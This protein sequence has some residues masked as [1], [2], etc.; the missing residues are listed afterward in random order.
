M[1][2][3]LISDLFEIRT[4]YTFRDAISDLEPGK[5]ALV[6]AGDINTNR[7]HSVSRINFSGE[8]H[9]L[10]VNDILLSARG[11]TAARTVT[12]DFLPAVAGSS[13]IVLRPKSDHINTRF[14]A[15]Y[16]NSRY[17]QSAFRKI[18]SGGYIKTLRKT[19]LEEILVPLPAR[20]TQ[21][22]LVEL[23]VNISRQKEILRTKERL[24]GEVYENAISSVRGENS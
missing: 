4:G 7:L 3:E 2:M 9:L 13:V 19:E 8:K 16:L 17:G 5:V 15:T 14:V 22:A 24:L 21:D 1:I 18:M 11:G 23:G 12:Q 10:K 20:S 6:Q